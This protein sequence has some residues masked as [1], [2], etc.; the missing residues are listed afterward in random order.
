MAKRKSASAINNEKSEIS[1][2]VSPPK[3]LKQEENDYK[4]WTVSDV[5]NFLIKNGL[6]DDVA[7][8]FVGKRK[9]LSR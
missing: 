5:N 6:E 7:L 8:K 1:K 4:T 3:K 2:G 9:I